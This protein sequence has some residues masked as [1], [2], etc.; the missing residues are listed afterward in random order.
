M[1]TPKVLGSAL[2]VQK[3]SSGQSPTTN[4]T[5]NSDAVGSEPS[6]SQVQLTSKRP[7]LIDG[8][9]YDVPI[10]RA[11]ARANGSPIAA[12]R[13]SM[14]SP[15]QYSIIKELTS[16]AL[17]GMNNSQ[18]W[19]GNPGKRG[20]MDT[21]WKA[22]RNSITP[23]SK[24][25]K[26]E[27]SNGSLNLQCGNSDP[28]YSSPINESPRLDRTLTSPGR[29]GISESQDSVLAGSIQVERQTLAHWRDLSQLHQAVPNGNP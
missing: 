15:A 3:A 28:P 27:L 29:R 17:N 19:R 9:Q 11:R 25:S 7:R 23:S 10:P 12:K 14:T 2:D 22:N 20:V 18:V 6:P 16:S 26:E 24:E 4:T 21:I 5:S 1:Q 13:R 8:Q